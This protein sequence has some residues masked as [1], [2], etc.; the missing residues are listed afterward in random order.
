[1]S[2]T[3][4]EGIVSLLSADGD[5]ECDAVDDAEEEADLETVA[6]VLDENEIDMLPVRVKADA[7]LSADGERLS[8]GCRVKVGWCV[9]D[10]D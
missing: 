6:E 2:L 1:M 3:D 10:E 5:L 8:V 4:A 7:V 9:T